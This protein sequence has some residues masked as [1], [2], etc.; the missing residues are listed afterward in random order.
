MWF[1]K[2]TG[3]SEENHQQ[4][5]GNIAIKG[6]K[7]ISKINN[8]EY[9]FGKLETPSLKEL[10]HSISL[11]KY[12]SKIKLSELVGDIQSIHKQAKNNGAMFQVA[13]QF[14]LLEMVSP[15]ITPENGV[16]IYE[17]DYTQGPACAIACGAGTIYRNYFA[18]TNGVIG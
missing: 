1:K 6:N 15:M 5:Q 7:L 12:K 9:T 13:S 8:K 10:K 4:V 3:F 14:N 2:L 17:N 11:Q 16:G 18:D